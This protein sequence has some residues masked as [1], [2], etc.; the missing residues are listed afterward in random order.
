[1]R[2]HIG[3]SVESVLPICSNGSV[4]LNKMATMSIYGRNSRKSSSPETR[5]GLI[6]GD[7]MCTILINRLED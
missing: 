5:M 4:Q 1:M 6:S 7:R 2:F 3:L